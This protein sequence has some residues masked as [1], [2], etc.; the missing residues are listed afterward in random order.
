MKNVIFN[1]TRWVVNGG[2]HTLK[3]LRPSR[4]TTVFIGILF[5]GV[6][7]T[8]ISIATAPQS[9]PQ[10]FNEKTWPVSVVQVTPAAHS[11][12]LEIYGR[13]ET[14]N[15]SELTAALSAEVSQLHIR[16]GES[17]AKG[18][19][20]I[21]LDDSDAVLQVKQREA[22]LAE[23][24]AFTAQLSHQHEIDQRVLENQQEL[25]ALTEAKLARYKKLHNEKLISDT[26]H[27]DFI[28]EAK[29]ARIALEQQQI[30]IK[31]APNVMASA[32]AQQAKAQALL[33]QAQLQ[34]SRCKIVAP[35]DGKIMSIHV[36]PGNRV[37]LGSPLVKLYDNLH[38]DVRVSLSQQYATQLRPLITN[39]EKV[40][41]TTQFGEKLH[42]QQLVSD[43][44][45][46]RS[47][48]DAIFQFDQDNAQ[49]ALGSVIP[50]ELALPSQSDLLAVPVQS[51]YDN[52]RIYAVEEDRLRAFEVDII[53]SR[54]NSE[55]Q[56]L[57]LV[58]NVQIDKQIPV[59]STQL[60][61]ALTGMKVEISGADVAEETGNEN[62]DA[63]DEELMSQA[64]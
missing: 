55:G 32:E 18:Q 38:L 40:I 12:T 35:F 10:E 64:G 30:K 45:K 17:V 50:L 54:T 42:L 2:V 25:F 47:G 63:Q 61:N 20:L 62:T 3:A 16:E 33:E 39:K 1:T 28:A 21:S 52:K 24:R 9:A 13:V 27:D 43:V 44:D 29:H 15:T 22:D 48:I 58:R 46:G 41:A 7:A 31:N 37:V 4:K 5:A 26:Q 23:A 34:L 36:A 56:H 6:T 49:H 11:P 14:P 59:L 8:A 53:G 57:L 60:P 19:V 51:V